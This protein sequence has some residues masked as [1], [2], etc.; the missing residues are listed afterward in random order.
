M[1]VIRETRRPSCLVFL[2]CSYC[3]LFSMSPVND[4]SEC[5]PVHK[6]KQSS[7]G[8]SSRKVFIE[9][10]TDECNTVT[11]SALEDSTSLIMNS[12]VLSLCSQEA[13][14]CARAHASS[15]LPQPVQ[16]RSYPGRVVR[17]TWLYM[18]LQKQPKLCP[19]TCRKA[20]TR[21]SHPW[22]AWH[23]LP[24]PSPLP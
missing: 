6:R 2:S 9:H 22:R 12:R 20:G 18:C 4:C 23:P 5:S 8:L 7:L 14:R 1:K 3:H 16:R 10:S 15:L 21:A 11:L 13:S 17:E 24:V 19:W